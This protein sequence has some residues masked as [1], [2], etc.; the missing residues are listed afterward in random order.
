M[1]TYR[2]KPTSHY[3]GGA[4]NPSYAY[5]KTTYGDTSTSA[6]RT[7]STSTSSI[8]V[9]GCNNS[10]VINKINNG[11]KITSLICHVT[12]KK[13]GSSTPT[14]KEV[15]VRCIYDV[16][17]SNVGYWTDAGDDVKV[18]TKNLST[19]ITHYPPISFPNSAAFFNSNPSKFSGIGCRF[20]GAYWR[21]YD[22]WWEIDLEEYGYVTFDSYFSFKKWKDSGIYGENSLT[23]SNLSDTGFTA[24]NTSSS[25]EGYTSTSYYYRLTEGSTYTMK[26]DTS[27]D[28]S[29][30]VFWFNSNNGSS[31]QNPPSSTYPEFD[32]TVPSGYPYIAHRC[33]VNLAGRVINYSNFRVVPANEKWRADTISNAAQRTNTK[34]VW[35]IPTPT[36]TGYT[37]NGWYDAISGGTKYTSSSTFPANDLNLWSHWSAN[38][39]SIKFNGNGATSGSMVNQLFNYDTAQNLTGNSFKRE[40]TVSLNSENSIST[41][42]AAYSFNGWATNP[43]GSKV[44]ND[45]QN[46]KNLSSTNNATINLYALWSSTSVT[47]PSPT[48]DGYIFKGWSDGENVY[49]G[50]FSYTPNNN[51]TLM[52]I[53]EQ[54]KILNIY[55]DKNRVKEIYIG[56]QKVKE[57][58]IGTTKVYG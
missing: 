26:Y 40:Y 34:G 54:D 43:T 36:R 42:T 17:G 58:Y 53:W 9:Y 38:T 37:F 4:T 35:N 30:E 47:L 21:L 55:I 50:G 10:D 49:T 2:F 48:R 6:Y 33:D 32:F 25:G 12:A 11:A 1:A 15:S 5:D 56:T 52:A 16:T 23:I 29:H 39:Y 45:K 19:T 51:I 18:F 46:V 14:T 22:L 13:Y 31:W 28:S 20:W 7:S 27:G 57:V 24:T 8:V 44:Y 41:L 3:A